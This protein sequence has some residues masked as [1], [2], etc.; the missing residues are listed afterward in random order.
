MGFRNPITSATAVDTRAAAAT[1]GVRVYETPNPDGTGSSYGVVEWSDG[2]AGDVPA[3]AVQVASPLPR[4]VTD[5][6]GRW[7]ISGGT[8][9]TPSGPV[10]APS[11]SLGVE[12]DPPGGP[13]VSEALLTSPGGL[14]VNS[15]RVDAIGWTFHGLGDA[16][17]SWPPPASWG[18]AAGGGPYPVRDLLAGEQ[19]EV[20]FS[21]ALGAALNPG[22]GLQLRIVF[23]YGAGN[24]YA[25]DGGYWS[26]STA[27]AFAVPTRLNATIDGPLTGV[28]YQLQAQKVGNQPQNM[29]AAGLSIPYLRH[30]IVPT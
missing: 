10:A 13:G 24:S 16:A 28:A 8:Y 7:T 5:P 14:K 17:Y 3:R 30:R 6:F 26:N 21:M 18:V 15:R 23:T 19:L 12:Q 27:S 1:A 29:Q 2:R 11:L 22:S 4:G 20:E 25:A 9:Q